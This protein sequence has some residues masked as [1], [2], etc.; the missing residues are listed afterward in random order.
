MSVGVDCIG[1]GVSAGDVSPVPSFLESLPAQ[2]A[3]IPSELP[4]ALYETPTSH[5]ASL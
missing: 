5:G 2:P 4:A 1:E 3:N